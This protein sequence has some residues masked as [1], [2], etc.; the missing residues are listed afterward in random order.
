MSSYIT[1]DE[2]KKITGIELSNNEIELALNNG[3]QKLKDTIFVKKSFVYAQPTNKFQIDVPLADYNA[4]GVADKKDISIYEFDKNDYVNPDTDLSDHIDSFNE[5]YGYIV[6]D[7][8]YPLVIGNNVVVDYYVAK[9]ENDKM[10]PYLKR[11]NLLMAS[12]T[13]FNNIP[14]SR[15]QE[16]IS[17]WNMNGVSVRFDLSSIKSIKEEIKLE[18][19]SLL[20]MVTPLI[21]EKTKF[22]FD[23]DDLKRNARFRFRSPSGNLYNLR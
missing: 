8:L 3:A 6:L 4:D 15:L 17:E 12:N 5:K 2:F 13:I 20:K 1:V 11:L 7:D 14:I 9:Y 10:K 22:G 18:I 21:Y 19:N 16:G 23:N